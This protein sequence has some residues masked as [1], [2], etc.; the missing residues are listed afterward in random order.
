MYNRRILISE[1]DR[2]RILNMHKNH[3][4]RHGLN[5]GTLNE[6]E[7]P[8][9]GWKDFQQWVIYRSGKPDAKTI[10][11]KGGDSGMGD[12][13]VA[14]PKTKAAWTAYGEEYKRAQGD[15]ASLPTNKVTG[16]DNQGKAITQQAGG[17]GT[18]NLDPYLAEVIKSYQSPNDPYYDPANWVMSDVP[19][20]TIYLVNEQTLGTLTGQ[21]VKVS[22]YAVN[23]VDGDARDRMQA[24]WC[25]NGKAYTVS[26]RSDGNAY[27]YFLYDLALANGGQPKTPPTEQYVINDNCSPQTVTPK[28]G[29]TTAQTATPQQGQTTTQQGGG[30]TETTAVPTTP[31]GAMAGQMEACKAKFPN[32]GNIQDGNVALRVCAWGDTADGQYIINLKPEQREGGMDLLEKRRNK[33]NPETRALKKEIRTALGMAAD[34]MLGRFG[35][36]VKGAVQGAVQGY[37]QQPGAPTA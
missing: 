35:Q 24:W 7:A 25:T 16:I 27:G 14:G 21:C 4:N 23:N 1:D 19:N 22:K 6:Q 17:G 12:D 31:Q 36:R 10:L 11:G 15:V 18:N 29:Q 30:G 13:G 28:Q 37:Q 26:I 5:F 34:T 9:K 3:A 8:K 33:N 32:I 2:S 20:G